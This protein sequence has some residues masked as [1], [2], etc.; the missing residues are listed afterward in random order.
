MT[1]KTK[2]IL[3]TGDYCR[4]E[5]RL[6]QSQLPDAQWVDWNAIFDYQ[7]PAA[8][9]L[10]CQS[11][12]D[13]FSQQA[14]YQLCNRFPLAQRVLIYGPWCQGE[15]RTGNALKGICRWPSHD[16][17]TL[18]DGIL[19]D[20]L[21]MPVGMQSHSDWLASLTVSENSN[22]NAIA[23]QGKQIGIVTRQSEFLAA[24]KEWGK[25][26]GA[27]VKRFNQTDRYDLLI[28]DCYFSVREASEMTN[29]GAGLVAV[30]G[31]PRSTD[32]K[33]LRAAHPNSRLIGKPFTN[34]Q[35]TTAVVSCLRRLGGA[36]RENS[37][38]FKVISASA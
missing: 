38:E 25:L 3:I 35:L 8:W 23:V 34:Q 29:N 17:W 22:S 6:L 13:E 26:L 33:L 12:R 32:Q 4:Q 30:C 24:I 18:I 36:V 28:V 11:R 27:D 10:V 5:F 31:F 1:R 20:N 7:L 2:P 19:A 37:P 9:L 21:M 14:I 15:T 16:L